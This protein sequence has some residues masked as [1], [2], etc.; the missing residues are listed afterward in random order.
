MYRSY[1]AR[2]AFLMTLDK[3]EGKEGGGSRKLPVEHKAAQAGHSGENEPM[4]WRSLALALTTDEPSSAA[5]AAKGSSPANAAKAPKERPASA[6]AQARLLLGNSAPGGA[7]KAPS[8]RHRFEQWLVREGV[9][10]AGDADCKTMKFSS[11]YY[12]TLARVIELQ[13][14]ML[15]LTS[16]Q[17]LT[18]IRLTWAQ[19]PAVNRCLLAA[20][21]LE[22][23]CGAQPPPPLSR[24]GCVEVAACWLIVAF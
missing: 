6:G 11:E 2:S 1:G 12:S 22:A 24:E 4:H 17:V 9:A 14:R 3:D 21:Q 5:A 15:P 10:V 16:D 13:A 23:A 7:L 18:G 19:A 8:N 20:L